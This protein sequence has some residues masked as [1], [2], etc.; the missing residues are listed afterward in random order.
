MYCH[1]LVLAALALLGDLGAAG[2]PGALGAATN[3]VADQAQL[4]QA[5]RDSNT[6]DILVTA[7]IRLDKG[8]W[9]AP[10]E[11]QRS[12]KISGLAAAP[13]ALDFSRLDGIWQLHNGA[14]LTLSHLEL[15]NLSRTPALSV[16]KGEG[17]SVNVTLQRVLLR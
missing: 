1:Y 8:A 11:V 2:S 15:A 13:T 3:N 5:M 4:L 14:S 10:V 16:I 6:S 17:G 9:V 7:E 12:L